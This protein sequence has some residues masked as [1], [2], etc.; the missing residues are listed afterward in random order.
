MTPFRRTYITYNIKDI[1]NA[2]PK[3]DER[4]AITIV[5]LFDVV[6]CSPIELEITVVDV[7]LI[8]D[9]DTGDNKL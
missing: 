3:T 9:D 5:L 2:D 1:N 8:V 6:E 7:V 4:T